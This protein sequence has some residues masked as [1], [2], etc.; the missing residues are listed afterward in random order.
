M[1]PDYYNEDPFPI[2]LES[3][4]LI[5]CYMHANDDFDVI[6]FLQMIAQGNKGVRSLMEFYDKVLDCYMRCNLPEGC[7]GII[8]DA[9]EVL[10]D[11]ES[12]ITVR[13][14]FED[15]DLDLSHMHGMTRVEMQVLILPF[16]DI[17]DAEYFSYMMRKRRAVQT[18]VDGEKHIPEE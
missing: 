9:Q 10:I 16:A 7:F 12:D 18:W 13:E 11:Y 14:I 4:S 3:D 5:D 6:D 17:D 2:N 1:I 8:Y 15:F